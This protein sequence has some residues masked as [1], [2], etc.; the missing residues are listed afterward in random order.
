MHVLG[1]AVRPD[2]Q[3]LRGIAVLLVV[4]YHFRLPPISGGYL[5]VDVFFVISGF[6]ITQ[7]IAVA[8]DRG[9][10]QLKAFYLRRAWRLLPAA[11][12]VIFAVVLLSPWLLSDSERQDLAKQVFGT[13]FLS[14]NIALWL[15]TGYFE[16]AATLKPLLHFWSLAIEE[17]YYLLLPATLLFVRKRWRLAA[18][19]AA[20]I[21]SLVLCFVFVAIKPGAVF[22]LLPTRMW[23]L[24]I[25]SIL[26]LSSINWVNRA[27]VARPLAVVQLIAL[28]AVL[29]LALSPISK[30]HPSVDAFVVCLATA[31]L[32][33]RPNRLLSDGVA[34]RLL[35]RVGDMSYSFYLVH[36][37]VV[38]FLN[39]MNVGGGGVGWRI[40][41]L[42]LALAIVL[43]ILLYRFVELRYRLH[44]VDSRDVRRSPVWLFSA[45]IVAVVGVFAIVSATRSDQ[46]LA[47]RLRGN[48][49]LAPECAQ[50][51]FKFAPSCRSSTS[52]EIIVWG[53]SY[54]MH[55]VTGIASE[56]TGLLQFT[57]AT[58]APVL[59]LALNDA[60]KSRAWGESCILFNESALNAIKSSGAQV[61]LL[62]A[63]WGY[64]MDGA[65]TVR[66]DSGEFAVEPGSASRFGERFAS[67]I[68]ALRAAGKR[69][70]VILPPPSPG[71]DAGRCQERRVT[72]L[73]S[74]GAPD[75]CNFTADQARERHAGIVAQMNQL[76]VKHSFQVIDPFEWICAEKTCSTMRDTTVLYRDAGHLSYE[77]SAAIVN[78]VGLTQK[79]LTLA[80]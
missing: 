67:T 22:Y 2:I 45:A 37:P 41:L 73:F 77:G 52:P 61:V 28:A 1:S 16:G 60:Q 64:I 3:S 42:G 49:G 72:G 68:D 14:A 53:D 40:R 46:N 57:R 15:Q 74:F 11:Y 35:G 62:G 9:T 10:F 78:A 71:F 21:M 54:A 30:V 76:A 56:G 12:A 58:C 44:K 36:W 18:I 66:K 27:D 25:G 38:A 23:E 19:F 39:S 26:A 65:Q 70:V 79:I 47:H 20:T 32:L 51:D 5:G 6:L 63:L 17:Q 13:V 33:L 7:Q 69:V 4:M 55:W 29:G 43:T 50:D 31:C 59:G 34:A 48:T 80:R 75:D 8:L 24:G